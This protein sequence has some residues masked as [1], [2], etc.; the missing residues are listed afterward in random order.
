MLRRCTGPRSLKEENELGTRK[1]M[2]SVVAGLH[3][4]SYVFRDWETFCAYQDV[5]LKTFR[6]TIL[7]FEKYNRSYFP[8]SLVRQGGG[9]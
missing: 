2:E 4:T 5:G 1:P 3:G 7:G 6:E 8:H 9:S